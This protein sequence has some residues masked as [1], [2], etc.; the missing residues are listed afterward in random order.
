MALRP[1]TSTISS[2]PRKCTIQESPI[3]YVRYTN[4]RMRKKERK[5]KLPP[6][7]PALFDRC[8]AQYQPQERL[9]EWPGR[10][11]E[12]IPRDVVG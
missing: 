10:N 5:A 3:L 4:P 11:L 6:E 9:S 2:R 8:L 1:P 7:F 12:Y